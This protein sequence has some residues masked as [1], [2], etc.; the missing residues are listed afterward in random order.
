MIEILKD[1][2]FIEMGFLNGN[3]FVYRC[4]SPVL[5]DTGYITEF[6][7]TEKLITQLGVKLSDISL[8]ISTHTPCDHIG[9][10]N[11]IQQKSGCNIALHKIGKYFIDSRDD[12]STC[13]DTITR[14]QSFLNAR[15]KINYFLT[16]PEAIGYDVLKKIIAYTLM[17]KKGIKA[18]TLFD[19]L[20]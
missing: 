17:M 16:H 7:E 11:L 12:W 5:I 8:I 1:L 6:D 9:G 13:G 20:K 15:K 3:H 14:R 2:Y 19:Y 4:H 10:N 18:D